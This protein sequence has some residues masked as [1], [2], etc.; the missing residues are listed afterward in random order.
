MFIQTKLVMQR[1]LRKGAL[2]VYLL[3]LL[4]DASAQ[5]GADSASKQ[6][7]TFLAGQFAVA[8]PFNVEYTGVLPYHYDPTF[9]NT[10]LPQGRMNRFSQLKASANFNFI[11]QKKWTM[12][13]TAGYRYT[14]LSATM[15]SLNGP[16]TQE[17]NNDFHYLS[18]SLNVNYFS[19][20]FNKMVV[21]SSSLI[22][23]GSEN[24]FGRVKALLSATMIL[25]ADAK[26][27]MSA[28]ILANIDA[29]SQLPVFPLFIYENK[30]GKGWTADII[31][32]RQ[33]LLRKYLPGRSRLSVGTTLD[34][35]IF[36]I[37]DLGAYSPQ[38]FEYRQTDISNGFTYER[39][40]GS[41][42]IFTARTGLRVTTSGRVFEKSKSFDDAVF[43][44]SP[45]PGF[46]FNAGI[47]FNSFFRKKK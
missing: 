32:P 8:R 31:L 13:F 5:S 35:T 3:L 44:I 19:R 1:L 14:N 40:L 39:L 9:A 23:D 26:I 34:A 33:L 38:K 18:G 28:G 41:H 6:V 17:V 43:E 46:Y 20:L 25:R 37:N 45:K 36:Y 12:G 16:E 47:S 11:K 29:G 7:L 30:L 22:A 10:K 2:P 42:F 21:Y 15:R 27:R 4:C 24:S